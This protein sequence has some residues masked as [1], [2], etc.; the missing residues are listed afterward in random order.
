[1]LVSYDLDPSELLWQE[2]LLCA[3]VDGSSWIVATP[4]RDI[5]VEDL[6][7]GIESLVLLGPI[8]GLPVGWNRGPTYI[9]R[10]CRQGPLGKVESGRLQAEGEELA[11]AERRHLGAS[12]LAPLPPPAGPPRALADGGEVS[13]GAGEWRFMENRGGARL[14]ER[15]LPAVLE[16]GLCRGDRGIVHCEGAPVTCAFIKVGEQMRTP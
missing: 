10:G 9:F 6:E 2:R 3:H 4:D 14:G 8:G 12:A 1:M 7:E 13:R 15:V 16:A 11:E 5:Y